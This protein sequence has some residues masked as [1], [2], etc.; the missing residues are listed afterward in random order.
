MAKSFD[1]SKWD[2]IELSDDESD[3]HPNIDKE[4]WFRLKHRTRLEREE[5]E[6]H[7]VREYQSKSAQ[8]EARVKLLQARLK[9][10]ESGE[11]DDAEFVDTE[12]LELE[13]KE[14]QAGIDNRNKRIFEIQERRKW[15]IDNIC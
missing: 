13:L 12:A 4:S 9:G 8:E 7:E 6:D 15:N 11:G 1:Y 2:N 14:L 3:L 5:K 10:V